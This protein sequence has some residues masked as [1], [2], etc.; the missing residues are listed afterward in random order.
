[1]PFRVTRCRQVS[2]HMKDEADAVLVDLEEKG[3]LRQV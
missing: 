2:W 1:M 3:V